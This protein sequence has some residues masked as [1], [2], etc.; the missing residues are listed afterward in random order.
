MEENKEYILA[1]N[2]AEVSEKLAEQTELLQED[3]T[4]ESAESKGMEPEDMEPEDMEPEGGRRVSLTYVM[5]F[6]DIWSFSM[7]Y[8]LTGINGVTF[9]F[10]MALVIWSLIFGDY[11]QKVKIIL[12]IVAVF[13]AWMTFGTTTLRAMQQARAL[14]EAKLYTTYTAGEKGITVMQGDAKEQIPY[15]R[16][17]KLKITRNYIYAYV[18]KNSAFIFP[19]DLLG[20]DAGALEELLR[21]K[22]Q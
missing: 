7:R 10:V 15:E 9:W 6:R 1:E 11:T 17:R 2:E 19:K 12:V 4:Q 13:L 21:E 18:M 20:E 8:A 14:D 16:I 5:R 3:M 22:L